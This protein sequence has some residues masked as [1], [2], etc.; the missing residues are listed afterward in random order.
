[1][2]DRTTATTPERIL[3]AAGEI[4]GREGFKAATIRRIAE[5]ANAN[6]ASINYHFRDKEGLY[7][8]VLEHLFNTG[9]ARFPADMG[10]GENPL[11]ED[12]LRAFI[13]GMFHRLLSNDGWGG[14]SGPGRLIAREF[15]EPTPSFEPIIERYIRPH[16][17]VLM[18]IMEELLGDGPSQEIMS[19][20]CL[21]IIGQCLYYTMGAPV[22]RRLS[23]HSD[24]TEE[25]IEHLAEFV[26][27][28]SLGGIM[29]IKKEKQVQEK[30]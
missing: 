16:K 7:A 4:F 6:V 9:F 27:R 19:A 5:T 17:N 13:R 20:C 18:S 29:E 1:M 12:R 26:Y 10:L 30:Q 21:S 8:A 22:I 15:H 24:P 28:F 11:P 2:T 23:R 25:D 14:M 3:E